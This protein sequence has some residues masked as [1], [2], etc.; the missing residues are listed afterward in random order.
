M[1][2]LP[3]R[4]SEINGARLVEAHGR[5][6]IQASPFPLS[7][8]LQGPEFGRMSLGEFVDTINRE[9]LESDE[10][11]KTEK[12]EKKKI[13][14][15]NDFFFFRLPPKAAKL[16]RSTSCPRHVTRLPPL[17]F[18]PPTSSMGQAADRKNRHHN[19]PFPP[20]ALPVLLPL[21]QWPGT[22]LSQPSATPRRR[23]SPHS[24]SISQP[25]QMGTVSLPASWPRGRESRGEENIA[26]GGNQN[27]G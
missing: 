21:R 18:N 10:A 15:E 4:R 3:C 20:P 12:E 16:H 6:R 13:G 24:C 19:P 9:W 17:S 2:R 1:P 22:V 25:T 14:C 26:I 27:K 8:S 7:S 5:G 23:A 11:T